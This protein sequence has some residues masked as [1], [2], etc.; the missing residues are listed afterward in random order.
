M[1]G[2]LGVL[3]AATMLLTVAVPTGLADDGVPTNA[4]VDAPAEGSAWTASENATVFIQ[5]DDYEG[6]FAAKQAADNLGLTYDFAQG[7]GSSC[8]LLPAL[9][10]G[11]YDLVVVNSQTWSLSYAC[12]A[13]IYDA[14]ADHAAGPGSLVL[15]SWEFDLCGT[16]FPCTT[17]EVDNVTAELGAQRPIGTHFS[18]PTIETS[19]LGA[20]AQ[21][22]MPN[23]FPPGGASSIEPTQDRYVRDAQGVVLAPA[24]A[25]LASQCFQTQGAATEAQV[26]TSLHGA[27]VGVLPGNYVGSDA[28]LDTKDDIVELYEDL[29]SFYTTV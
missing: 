25:P 9:Q 17:A 21:T 14:L 23:L 6:Y 12:G 13:G 18:P 7:G 27:Y 26:T 28:D 22:L 5:D 15:Q 10:S 8:P 20:C 19:A 11:Q 24:G 3:I 29:L 2:T 4:E 16:W 1:R